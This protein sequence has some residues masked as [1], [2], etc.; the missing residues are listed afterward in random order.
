MKKSLTGYK[1]MRHRSLL[2]LLSLVLLLSACAST[3]PRDPLEKFNRGVYDLN[4]TLD[5]A[6]LKPIAE[7]Y[8]TTVP[9]P[10]D[11]GVSNFFSNLNT[12]TVFANNLFQLKLKQASQDMGRFLLNS[13]VGFFGFFDPAT[14]YGIPRHNEDFGQTLGYWGI[15][16]GPY[17]ML[18]FLGPSTLRDA[19]ALWVD[20]M[21]DPFTGEYDNVAKRELYAANT[22]KL[23]DTRA[24]L[25]N[26]EKLLD[27]AIDEY[28]FIRNAYL[29]RRD[30]LVRDG[31]D[32]ES[33]I[34]DDEL[35]GD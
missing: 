15:P 23:L 14:D 1:K 7:V 11:T 20:W 19:P 8:K 35:F 18:P 29:Q 25:L 2:S 6:L 24:D 30:S 9:E 34:S 32:V 22:L 17:L 31:M 13:S 12:V 16:S 21:L 28:A 4:R 5:K 3:H 26:A 33:V 27:S 10:I